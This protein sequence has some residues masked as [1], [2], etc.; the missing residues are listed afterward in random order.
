MY[1]KK[2]ERKKISYQE[3]NDLYKVVSRL[4]NIRS[5]KL[6]ELSKKK[7][8]I[9]LSN[10]FNRNI[11]FQDT[12]TTD[13]TYL[14]SRYGNNIDKKFI[15]TLDRRLKFT[16]KLGLLKSKK[17][18]FN[19]RLTIELI[20]SSIK[21]FYRFCISFLDTLLMIKWGL[22]ISTLRL[23]KNDNHIKNNLINIKSLYSFVF[24]KDKLSGSTNYFYPDI[25][26]KQTRSGYA[27]CFYNYKFC[28]TGLIESG[29]HKK[30]YT[31]L[32]LN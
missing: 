2:Y 16:Y 23:L 22:I 10:F 8:H 18:T 19:Y 24:M 12:C 4:K 15:N 9:L 17:I 5:L 14:I 21:F 3:I 13:A 6:L 31:F 29:K 11:F 30:I 27:A 28:I 1:R 25:N 20:K 26:N 32:D 7:P